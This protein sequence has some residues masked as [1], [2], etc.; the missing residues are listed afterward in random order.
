MIIVFD[1]FSNY[2]VFTIHDAEDT[3][4]YAISVSTVVFSSVLNPW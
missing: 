3:M 2:N 1:V 4:A